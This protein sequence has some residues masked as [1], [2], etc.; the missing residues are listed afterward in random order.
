MVQAAVARDAEAADWGGSR[1]AQR[2][3]GWVA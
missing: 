2:A 1:V 3:E